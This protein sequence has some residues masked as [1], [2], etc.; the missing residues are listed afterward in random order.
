M[1]QDCLF[2][3]IVSGEIPAT[4]V[5]RDEKVVAFRDINPQAPTHILLIPT[6][7]IPDLLHLSI[8]QNELLGHI[9]SRAAQ[10]AREEGIAEDGFRLLANTGPAAGQTVLHL[11]FHLLGGRSLG[12]PPG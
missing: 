5:Y 4:I 6:I 8:E 12:W 10:L 1:S 11:H 7:H 3:R 9:F 2:C